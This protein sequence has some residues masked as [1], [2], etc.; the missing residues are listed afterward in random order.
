MTRTKKVPPV[1]IRRISLYARQLALLDLN[2]ITIV[3]S[4]E[5]AEA[6]N[7]NSA[8]IRKDFAYFGEF[9]IRGTGYYVKDLLSE[10][11]KAL[12]LHK[13]WRLVLVGAGH[14]GTALAGYLVSLNQGYIFVKAFDRDPEKIGRYMGS[15]PIFSVE[16]LEQETKRIKADI[17][18]IATNDGTAQECANSLIRGGVRGILNFTPVKL[19]PSDDIQ[20][21]Q[22]DFSIRLDSLCYK[23]S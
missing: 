22:V 5:L 14:L 17:G 13:Q 2:N 8:Q 4:T 1:A 7:V 18:I 21:E 20:I 6:C 19:K 23:L 10:L 12:G 9:G 3:S 11:R 16:N 15:I